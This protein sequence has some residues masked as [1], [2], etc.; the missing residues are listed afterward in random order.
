MI[1]SIE[2]TTRCMTPLGTSLLLS[3]RSDPQPQTKPRPSME[4]YTR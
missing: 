1:G 2:P 4:E 3:P